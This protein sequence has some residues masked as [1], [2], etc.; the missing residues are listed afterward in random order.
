MQTWVSRPLKPPPLTNAVTPFLTT[1]NSGGQKNLPNKE[2]GKPLSLYLSQDSMQ[3]RETS[4]QRSITT[5]IPTTQNTSP[6]WTC[7]CYPTT[8]SHHCISKTPDWKQEEEQQKQHMSSDNR[9][10]PKSKAKTT[11]TQNSTPNVFGSS[12]ARNTWWKRTPHKRKNLLHF[13]S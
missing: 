10:L 4:C 6:K 7:S 12:Q 1:Q 2:D 11:T 9:K 8:H 3:N 13:D 5:K